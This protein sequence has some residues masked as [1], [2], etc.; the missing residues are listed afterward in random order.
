M[1][2]DFARRATLSRKPQPTVRIFLQR[3]ISMF[4][5]IGL[6]STFFPSLAQGGPSE[7]TNWQEIKKKVEKVETEGG[8]EELAR[9]VGYDWMQSN[10]D[11]LGISTQGVQYLTGAT[12]ASKLGKFNDYLGKLGGALIV[13][14]F[15]S[16]LY[17]E[18]PGEETAL[19]VS[20]GSILFA[21]YLSQAAF[22]NGM[23]WAYA[24]LELS[25]NL[26]FVPLYRG[27]E[28]VWWQIYEDYFTSDEGQLEPRA[29]VRLFK[30]GDPS[31]YTTHMDS[32]FTEKGADFVIKIRQ[33]YKKKGIEIPT[34][35]NP[36]VQAVAV[37]AEKFRVRFYRQHLEKNLRKWA[38]DQALKE[39][40]DAITKL[41]E[42]LKTLA[43]NGVMRVKVV[44]AID[45]T[46]LRNAEVE[47]KFDN[48]ILDESGVYKRTDGDGVALLTPVAPWVEGKIH[49]EMQG[50][51][52]LQSVIKPE[53]ISMRDNPTEY[54]LALD[55]NPAKLSVTVLDAETGKPVDNALVS[56]KQRFRQ[57]EASD[58]TRNGAAVLTFQRSGEYEIKIHA[59]NYEPLEEI[60]TVD[61][62]SKGTVQSATFRLASGKSDAEVT[63]TVKEKRSGK[64]LD[65][66]AIRIVIG[67]QSVSDITG[68]DGKSTL[69]FKGVKEKK[70]TI[71]LSKDK[72]KPKKVRTAIE[73]GMASETVEMEQGAARLYVAVRDRIND[74]PIRNARVSVA[75]VSEHK[76]TDADGRA[77]MDIPALDSVNVTLSCEGYKT[78]GGTTEVKD[79]VA[80][81][82]LYLEPEGALLSVRVGNKATRTPLEGVLVRA[83]VNGKESTGTT[84]A[85][86][87]LSMGIPSGEAVKIYLSRKGFESAQTTKKIEG[88][89]VTASG[90]LQPIGKSSIVL[91]LKDKISQKPIKGA[92]A[93]AGDTSASTDKDGKASLPVEPE[94][95]ILLR[96]E[97]KG[98]NGRADAGQAPKTGETKTIGWY[99]E[100]LPTLTPENPSSLSS[101]AV[102]PKS[103]YEGT[104]TAHFYDHGWTNN[105]RATGEITVTLRAQKIRNKQSGHGIYTISGSFNAVTF[106]EKDP[107]SG[108]FS[109]TTEFVGE[110]TITIPSLRYR[111]GTERGR[112]RIVIREGGGL[113]G[114]LTVGS[115]RPGARPFDFSDKI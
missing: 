12:D 1:P 60:V 72:Y 9:E 102:P 100:P 5:L 75:G 55:P 37:H 34:V 38:Y 67:E 109:E 2:S 87:E 98:Y 108:S 41:K 113:Y 16:D 84:N 30:N 63:V 40:A 58:R 17:N 42:E 8:K 13:T 51:A 65:G 27:D 107:F 71:E 23:L 83:V 22:L 6:I 101:P 97:A 104:F 46:P 70:A 77:E 26:F 20:K 62:R 74:K 39:K 73:R 114:T 95:S 52:S 7:I 86:G 68:S 90:T 111:N 47:L 31:G 54:A 35:A 19:N 49:V 43:K 85:E 44:D 69:S 57:S 32:F 106:F 112:I 21:A 66:V 76:M 45:K 91:I 50:Y 10:L 61:G 103:G 110:S 15:L 36:Q 92:T 88:G 25:R 24:A 93:W 89:K 79:G 99:L 78:R 29:W 105:L 81:V 4:I 3:A 53:M 11:T 82:A 48:K 94:A 80:K 33:E 14:Q 96:A 18:K 64:A 56:G 115:G 59:D 28:T